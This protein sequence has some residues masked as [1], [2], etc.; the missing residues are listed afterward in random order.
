[1]SVAEFNE[2]ECLCRQFDPQRRDFHNYLDDL[3]D[4]LKTSNSISILAEEIR[5]FYIITNVQEKLDAGFD[6]ELLTSD[7]QVK[8]KK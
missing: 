8:Y 6:F 5:E 1:M 4:N 3:D 7:E 2:Y